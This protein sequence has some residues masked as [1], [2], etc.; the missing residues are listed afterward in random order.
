M[1]L[2]LLAAIAAALLFVTGLKANADSAQSN[3]ASAS[4]T[5]PRRA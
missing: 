1:I 5:G 2:A 3:D 4:A